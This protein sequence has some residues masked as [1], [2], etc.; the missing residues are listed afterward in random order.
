MYSAVTIGTNGGNVSTNYFDGCLDSISYYPRTKNTS[1]ILDD[2]TNVVYLS[3]DNNTLLDSGPLQINGTGVNHSF[4]S[5]CR[6]NQCLNLSVTLSY[7][8][9]SGL[10]RFG[11][12]NWPYTFSVWLYPTNTSGGTIVYANIPS[13][14]T[15]SGPTWCLPIIGFTLSKQISVNSWNQSGN[16]SLVGAVVPVLVW[17]HIATSYSPT[18]GLRLYINGTQYVSSSATFNFISSGIPM[19]LLIGSSL[20]DANLCTTG[21]VAI[22]QYRGLLDEFRLYARELTALEIAK[23][24]NP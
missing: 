9:V 11:T 7:I 21:M 3:F 4:A 10:R 23:L 13:D 5:S 16:V 15:K 22:G 2:S 19:N 18:N 6:V 17:T 14:G 12:S 8:R 20:S 24:A 1:E